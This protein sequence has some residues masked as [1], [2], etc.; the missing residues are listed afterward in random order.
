MIN[1]ERINKS[2]DHGRIRILEDVNF[3]VPKGQLV[4]LL[5]PSG[6]GKTTLLRLIAGLEN[7][8]SGTIELEGKPA[9]SK[10][11]QQRQVGFVFQ[12]YAL[13]RHM[14]VFNNVA[15]G[16]RVKPWFKRPKRK[17]IQ[18]KVQELLELV[19]IHELAK[20]YPSQLSGGQ[21]QRVALARALAIEPKILLLDEPFGA[22][23]A[24]VRQE[25][26]IWLRKLHDQM[27]LTTL[28]VTHDQQEAMDL[29]DRIILLQKG[30]LQ[31]IDTPENIYEKPANLFVYQFLGSFNTIRLPVNNSS[32]KIGHHVFQADRQIANADMG[33]FY[34]RPYHL[35]LLSQNQATTAH[36]Y[37]SVQGIL[38]NGSIIKLQIQPID[39]LSGIYEVTISPSD[40]HAH[41]VK[42]GAIYPFSIQ[43]LAFFITP[44]QPPITFKTSES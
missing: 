27:Q 34:I 42:N 40:Y 39:Y 21:R 32:I 9:Q 23:D 35:R 19:Q 38:F 26:R 44:Q 33:I 10:T 8:D 11:I 5:G 4:A 28:F 6:S 16:L 15:F 36:F 17:I 37:A 20:R 1:I 7:A 43:E 24:N 12:H 31:Q 18:Q 25:L 3:S 41:H 29:A 2:F 30:K 22:L 14:N 13:F